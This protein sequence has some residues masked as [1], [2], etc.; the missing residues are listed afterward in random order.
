MVKEYCL[1]LQ[2]GEPDFRL[3]ILNLGSRPLSLKALKKPNDSRNNPYRYDNYG[4]AVVI[5]NANIYWKVY[6]VLCEQMI[7][8]FNIKAEEFS[9]L[10]HPLPHSADDYCLTTKH[11]N[12]HIVNIHDNLSFVHIEGKIVDYVVFN[13]WTLK[14]SADQQ[15]QPPWIKIHKI[16]INVDEFNVLTRELPAV[17]KYSHLFKVIALENGE[18]LVQYFIERLYAYNIESGTLRK[19]WVPD[20]LICK[21]KICLY[22]PSLVSFRNCE[23]LIWI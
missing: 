8:T 14:D 18:L 17:K 2:R 20:D 21:F 4:P 13:V 7:L 16:T 22:V 10:A 15:Q 23:S 11:G 19:I 9:F 5:D 1:L 12:M 6:G 3:E